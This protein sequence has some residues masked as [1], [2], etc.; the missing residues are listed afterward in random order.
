MNP[1]LGAAA[2]NKGDESWDYWVRPDGW[3]LSDRPVWQLT[4]LGP[5]PSFSK[6]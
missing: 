6:R 3:A 1:Q 2:L 4:M 5:T